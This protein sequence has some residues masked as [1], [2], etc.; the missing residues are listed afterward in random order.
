MSEVYDAAVE[1]RDAVQ[2]LDETLSV[3]L[4]ELRDVLR[5]QN[6]LLLV[7]AGALLLHDPM[8]DPH[9]A[10]DLDLVV[11]MRAALAAAAELDQAD[12]PSQA[13]GGAS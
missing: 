10:E 3:A 9:D 11:Q 7:V 2:A 5:Q 13:S 1:V 12:R 8:N 4:G 6:R